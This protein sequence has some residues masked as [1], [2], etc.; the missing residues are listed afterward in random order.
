[1]IRAII[2]DN[3][4]RGRETLATLLKRHCPAVDVLASVN[5]VGNAVTAMQEHHPDLIFLDVE[6]PFENG[7]DLL[8]KTGDLSYEVIF[9][10]AYDRYAI[11]AIKSDALDYLLKPIDR[12]ELMGAVEKA[13]VKLVEKSRPDHEFEVLLE[14]LRKANAA[15]HRIALPTSDGLTC[16]Q[17]TDVIRCEA[18]DNYTRFYLL[19]GE[20]LLI[21]RTLKEFDRTLSDMG[22]LR[23]HNSH[24]INLHHTRK[25]IRGDGGHVIMCD[26][27]TVI[28]SRRKRDELI[29]RL[30]GA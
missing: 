4:R 2:V 16:V 8:K 14:N 19:S 3:E 10:T 17:I 15:H 20:V 26:N 11:P 29:Q 12:D 25:Y 23:V 9:T 7:F 1:M 13:R 30:A 28:I 6:M 5:S 21:T 27:S 18:V 22:F 24:L